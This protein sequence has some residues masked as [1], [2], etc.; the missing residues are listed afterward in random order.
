MALLALYALIIFVVFAVVGGLIV[1]MIVRAQ[2]QDPDGIHSQRG[3][4]QDG[5]DRDSM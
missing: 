5:T 2:S 3:I 1:F 4:P